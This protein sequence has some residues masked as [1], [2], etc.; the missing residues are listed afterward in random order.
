MLSP[1]DCFVGKYSNVFLQ[2]MPLF[3][4]VP[5]VEALVKE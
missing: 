4:F 2:I 5:D 1:V 3:M